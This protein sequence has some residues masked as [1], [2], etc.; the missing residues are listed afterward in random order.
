MIAFT[1]THSHTHTYLTK[2]RVMLRV[3]GL[4]TLMYTQRMAQDEML[5]DVVRCCHQHLEDSIL[6]LSFFHHHLL[7]QIFVSILV[8]PWFFSSYQETPNVLSAA[9][10][11]EWNFDFGASFYLIQKFLIL[12]LILIFRNNKMTQWRN[13][14]FLIALKTLIAQECANCA[15]ISDQV[16]IKSSAAKKR[17][18][19]F[20]SL[21]V[22]L[23]R[24][25]E[26][27]RER[28]WEIYQTKIV[29]TLILNIS[30]CT[31]CNDMK[32]AHEWQA[33]QDL[34]AVWIWVKL[35]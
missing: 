33:P 14:L 8:N 17:L 15:T 1:Y 9:T 13:L 25:R 34:Q 23:E 18:P 4:R 19:F 24:E 27:E 10:R 22:F 20:W 35:I 7:H 6:A 21:L 28:D 3:E 16:I 29:R 11:R 31:Y 32:L 30:A 12:I 26:R 2:K 5:W